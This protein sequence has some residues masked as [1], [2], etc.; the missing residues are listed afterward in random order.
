MQNELISIITPSYKSERFIS[1]TIESVL[2]Q[3]YQNWEMIVVDDVSLDNSSDIVEK[4]CK[5][6]NRIRLIK[7]EKNSGAA[8]A[9]NRAIKEAKGRYIAFLDADDI[10]K[11]EKL[12]KQIYFMQKNNY[13]F[14]YTAY[15]KIDENGV[16]F[17]KI[18]VPLKVS[19]N[20]LLKT[21]VIGCLTV[22]YDTEKLD[23]VYM[24]LIRKRQ[25]FGLWLKILKKVDFAYGI[26]EPLA[27]YT[28]REDSI[29]ANKKSAAQFTWKLYREIEKLNL[30]KACYYFSHYAIRGILR[31]KFPK[32]ARFI[33]FL[34]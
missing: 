3:T 16:V 25:D 6:D 12:E 7:L 11:A 26:N 32:I 1:Q 2:A 15:E 27:F 31:T 9:R 21:C 4:Y 10:W 30:L 8:V 13:S 17:G 29:S 22:I 18:G 5:K 14:T 23:K 24:P 34:D 28:V 33:G 19:Y 20:Q